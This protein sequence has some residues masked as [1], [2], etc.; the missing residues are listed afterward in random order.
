VGENI[1]ARLQVDQADADTRKAQ[2]FAEQR[3]AD[4]VALE[5]EMKALTAKNRAAVILA[6]AEV[7]LAM[8]DAFRK[9]TLTTA[10]RNGVLQPSSP[11]RR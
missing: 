8:G 3:R 5:Q 2:A 9:G 1:G 11:P 6:R 10:N 7:P 4:A